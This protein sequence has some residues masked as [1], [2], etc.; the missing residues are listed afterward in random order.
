MSDFSTI[1][2]LD[3]ALTQPPIGRVWDDNHYLILELKQT[4]SYNYDWQNYFFERQLDEH[5][6]MHGGAVHDTAYPVKRVKAELRRRFAIEQIVDPTGRA[7][8]DPQWRPFW[9]CRKK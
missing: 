2:R 3:W 5:F 6:L 7:E 9:V 8:A 1:Q 4:G